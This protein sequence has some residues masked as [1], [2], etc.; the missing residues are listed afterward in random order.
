MQFSKKALL[1]EHS[2]SE[3]LACLVQSRSKLG[4][5]SADMVKNQ[6]KNIFALET[7]DTRLWINKLSKK[8]AFGR[9]TNWRSVSLQ[10]GWREWSSFSISGPECSQ[11]LEWSP[12][13][14]KRNCENLLS[15]INHDHLDHRMVKISKNY[16]K[17][18]EGLRKLVVTQISV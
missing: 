10:Y 9:K 13:V 1:F 6:L 11:P 14:W 18:S 3:L 5:W 16:R 4:L 15:E 8:L 2:S 17:C 7:N 12:M